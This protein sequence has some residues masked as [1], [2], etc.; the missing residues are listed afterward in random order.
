MSCLCQDCKSLKAADAEVKS[1]EFCEFTSL[2]EVNGTEAE[3]C[4]VYT[5][6]K[7]KFNKALFMFRFFV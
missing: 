5:I 3:M 1:Q 4:I 6:T 7:Y 2:C